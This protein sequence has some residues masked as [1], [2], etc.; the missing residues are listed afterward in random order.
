M[1]TKK[2]ISMQLFINTSL[3]GLGIL[4][5][6]AFIIAAL[7][8]EKQKTEIDAQKETI[9]ELNDEL[10]SMEVMYL[11]CAGSVKTERHGAHY[12]DGKIKFYKY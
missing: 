10:H 8:V 4:I 7:K 12:V 5:M 11:K 1:N 6:T 3:A 2:E 9:H